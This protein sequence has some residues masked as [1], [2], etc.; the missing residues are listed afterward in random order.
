MNFYYFGGQF[1]NNFITR[2]NDSHFDGVMF[3]HDVTQGDVF[4]KVVKDMKSNEKIKYLVAIRPYTISP[5]YLCMINHSINLIERDRL[6]VNLISGYIK[7]YEQNFGGIIGDIND[8]SSKIDRSNYMIEYVKQLNMMPGNKNASN[9]LDFY[10]STTN[11]HTFA[12]AQHFRNKIILPYRDYKNGYWTHYAGQ[13][14][15]INDNTFSLAWMKVMVALTPIIRKTEE[16]LNLSP[17]YA[18]RPI[19]K[20]GEGKRAVT[21]VEYFTYE[22]FA[23]FIKKLESEGIH[24]LLINAWPEEE[25]EIIIDFVKQYKELEMSNK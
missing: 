9:K 14:G 15:P 19:W 10:V 25:R 7:D 21:D 2:L 12:I 5:Q 18:R 8:S 6:Q 16:E 4:T 23:D 17:D 13:E 3:V 20:K 22:S 11:E 1:H 24:H